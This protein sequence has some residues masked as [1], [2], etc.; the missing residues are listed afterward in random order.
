VKIISGGQTG[1]DRAALDAAIDLGLEYGGSI[2]KGR[3]AE[4]G[5]IDAKRY[6]HLTELRTASYAARTRRNVMDAD[7]TLAFT[8]GPLR[9]G[10]AET[11]RI[12]RARKKPHLVIDLRE[13]KKSDAVRVVRLWLDVQKPDVLNVAGSRESGAPAI[14][15]KVYWLMKEVLGRKRNFWKARRSE[16]RRKK[17]PRE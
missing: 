16:S 3:L 6:P 13:L 1:A 14:Y 8:D 2:P 9:G 15:G 7:A 4:D 10:T 12:A 11:I 17:R 5:T